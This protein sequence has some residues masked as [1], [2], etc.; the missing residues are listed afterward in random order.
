MVQG[1]VLF[2]AEF[3]FFF[4]KFFLSYISKIIIQVLTTIIIIS[5]V[6]EH[7]FYSIKWQI[8]VLFGARKFFSV[9]FGG[10]SPF[11][12]LVGPDSALFRSQNKKSHK[13]NY[14]INSSYNE[15]CRHLF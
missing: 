11:L 2:G 12:S 6:L 4:I 10:L 13:F 15:D 14:L 5:E 8:E 1:R 9:L 3:H 7:M